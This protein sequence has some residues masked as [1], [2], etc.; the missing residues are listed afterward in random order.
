MESEREIMTPRIKIGRNI[1]MGFILVLLVGGIGIMTWWSWATKPYVPVGDNE[2][3]TI[4]MGTTV[5]QLAE[6]LQER[7]LIRSAL[8]FR[9]IVHSEQSDFKI[10]AG[11][12]LLTPAMSPSEMIKRFLD[13]SAALASNRVTIP[14]GY[15]TEQIIDLLVLKGIANKE[16]FTKVVKDDEFPYPFLKDAPKGIHRL[17]GYLF[18][19]TYD[20]PVKTNPHQMI[21]LL[22]RQFAKELTPD[23]QKQLDTSKLS[24]AQWVTLGS[25]VEK[26][27]VKQEDRPK[28]ASV[29]LNRLKIDQPLQSCATIQFLLG[30]PKEKLYNKD[31]QIP[32][33]YNTYLH[34]G[35][36]P[37]PIANPGHASLQAVLHP[38]E[39]EM[40][41]FV[42]KKDGYHAFA[43]TY[44]EHLENIKR[45]L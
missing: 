13:S 23:V 37:G 32:S 2:K 30:T 36:P 27:A 15:T 45:D 4:A 24:V 41:Y 9:Y 39:S 42:A 12:Y 21:D 44:A 11:D 16:A 35:L 28:V 1:Y 20:I 31:L 17:E 43:K 14:E 33:P 25:M 10:Y 8:M 19:N 3:I 6:K 18:P 38:T 22:L 29:F 26:E 40:L 34:K 5:P 7:H